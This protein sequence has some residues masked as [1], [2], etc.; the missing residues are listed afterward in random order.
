MAVTQF[1]TQFT[2]VSR[3][4]RVSSRGEKNL[5]LSKDE[6]T[7]KWFMEHLFPVHEVGLVVRVCNGTSRCPPKA[8]ASADKGEGEAPGRRGHSRRARALLE[9]GGVLGQ[10]LLAPPKN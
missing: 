9:D 3:H 7:E 8:R 1:V 4:P 5:I 10:S 6:R 2:H